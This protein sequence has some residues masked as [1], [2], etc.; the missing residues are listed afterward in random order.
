[1][2]RLAPQG[3]ATFLSGADAGRP[4]AA[5]FP[6]GRLWQNRPM[7]RAVPRTAAGLALAIVVLASA[8]CG[9]SGDEKR[10][11]K[12]ADTLRDYY[13]RFWQPPSPDWNVMKVRVTKDNAVTVDANLTTEALT[14]TVMERSRAEQMEIARMACPPVGEK[15]VWKE[16]GKKQS[17]GVALSGSAGH[18]INAQCKRP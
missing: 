6:G 9:D 5:L 2:P 14:K 1:L 11:K 4:G 3:G 13:Y 12:A 7:I 16:L 15:T 10:A 17:I 8:G 18:I